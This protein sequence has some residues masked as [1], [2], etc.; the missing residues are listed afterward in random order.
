MLRSLRGFC[1]LRTESRIANCSVLQS[2]NECPHR[3]ERGYFTKFHE[4]IIPYSR[5]KTA[6]RLQVATVAMG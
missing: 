6:P 5:S 4:T 3:E 2:L 1:F